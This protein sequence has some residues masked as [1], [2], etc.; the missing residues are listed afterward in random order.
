MFI[1]KLPDTTY[2]RW[3]HKQLVIPP[4]VH[5]AIVQHPDKCWAYQQWVCELLNPADAQ[6]HLTA[7]E[8]WLQ[9]CAQ[10]GFCV[11]YLEY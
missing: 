4:A 11:E 8:S 7:F 10:Q 9:E 3:W 6:A 5:L 1:A 2:V